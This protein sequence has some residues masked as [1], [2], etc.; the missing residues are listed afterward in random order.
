MTDQSSNS[1]PKANYNRLNIRYIKPVDLVDARDEKGN[2]IP[3][4]KEQGYEVYADE[5]AG[6]TNAAT[7]AKSGNLIDD[8]A[9]KYPYLLDEVE[10]YHVVDGK[11]VYGKYRTVT[12][13]T[14]IPFLAVL[15][16]NPTAAQ[17]FKGPGIN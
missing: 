12:T 13:N 8:V 15:A 10:G 11:L 6:Y 5:Y 3:G 4:Q 16:S 1:V 2:I 17:E 14:R 9:K 7:G